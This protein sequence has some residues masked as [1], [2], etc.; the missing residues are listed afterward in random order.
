MWRIGRRSAFEQSYL[1]AAEVD[2][3]TAEFVPSIVRRAPPPMGDEGL[4]RQV[5]VF[6]GANQCVLVTK[7]G[8]GIVG[9]EHLSGRTL[10]RASTVHEAVGALQSILNGMAETH[11]A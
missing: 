11:Q 1:T 5:L 3:I 9:T 7:R 4:Y 10:F 6:G 2:P 8:G